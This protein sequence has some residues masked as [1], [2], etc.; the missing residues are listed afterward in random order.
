MH[1]LKSKL[2]YLQ[3]ARWKQ[4]QLV[5]APYIIIMCSVGGGFHHCRSE[6]GGGFCAYADITLSIRVRIA[7]N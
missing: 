3:V 2:H 4:L 5:R 1:H 6:A 7:V